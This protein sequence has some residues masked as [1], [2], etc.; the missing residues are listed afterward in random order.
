MNVDNTKY[1][2]QMVDHLKTLRDLHNQLLQAVQNKQRTMRLGDING[3]ESWTAREIFITQQIKDVELVRQNV[4]AQL[5]ISLGFKETPRI[6]VLAERLSEPNRSRL[7]A[8]SGA[9]RVSVKE[10]HK[11]SQINDA[12]SREILNCFSNAHQKAV[13]TKKNIELYDLRGQKQAV[14]NFNILDAVG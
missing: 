1:I 4:N 2:K 7:I 6:S 11:I 12:V 3:M 9:I 13:T 10:I 5:A 14:S 8:L